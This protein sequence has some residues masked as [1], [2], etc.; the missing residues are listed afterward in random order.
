MDTRRDR[1][2]ATVRSSRN[3]AGLLVATLVAGCAPGT[4]G[5]DDPGPHPLADQQARAFDDTGDGGVAAS[6][7][8][9]PSSRLV[10]ASA[11]DEGSFERATEVSSGLHAPMFVVTPDNADSVADEVDR[12]GA[13]QVFVVGAGGSGTNP[14]F[15]TDIFDPEIEVSAVPSGVPLNEVVD[16]LGED[17]QTP[18]YSG[19]D[20]RVFVSGSTSWASVATARASG[21]AVSRLGAPDPRAYGHAVDG[22]RDA[23]AV[24]AFGPDW[25]D[26]FGDRAEQAVTVPELPGGGQVIFPGRRM[27]GLYGSPL[28]PALGIL[29]EQ[30]PEAAVEVVRQKVEEY[31]EFSPEPVIPAFEIIGTVAAQTPGPD[32][33]YSNVW[34]PELFVPMVDAITD[35]GGYA[36]I[37]LQPGMADFLEQARPFEELLR[38]PGVG[39]ALDPEW[40]LAPDQQPLAQVGSVDAA[41][42]NRVIDWL[43]EITRDSGGPQTMLILHQFQDQMITDRDQV[44]TSYDEVSV[45]LHIDGH[46]TPGEKIGTWDRMLED[47]PDGMWP[48]WKNFR[49]EDNPTFTSQETMAVTPRPWF[50]SYQ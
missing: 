31:Q 41:E 40:R 24:L 22:I 34:D 16:E 30:D 36:L 2:P 37:D 19:D 17:P 47:L 20:V 48:A 39:L 44:D 13:E 5:N 38:R 18:P 46:G 25:G 33:S 7:Q 4:D 6:E 27:V 28:T 10:V 1:F 14:G 50:V 15:D 21:A 3:V 9:F 32:G 43:A 8:L 12:L 26:G 11:S 49:N 45:V 29:G 35:A 42:I 23:E